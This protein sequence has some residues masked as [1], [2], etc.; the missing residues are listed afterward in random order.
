MRVETHGIPAPID[1]AMDDSCKRDNVLRLDW[2]H[3]WTVAST[4]LLT[5]AAPRSTHHPTPSANF[6]WRWAGRT[7]K[8]SVAPPELLTRASK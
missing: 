3:V 6:S 8:R 1:D 7:A 5:L 2:D 4:L